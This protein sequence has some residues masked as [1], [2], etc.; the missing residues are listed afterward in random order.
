[1]CGGLGRGFQP[2]LRGRT[3]SEHVVF[4]SACVWDNILQQS[5]RRVTVMRALKGTRRMSVSTKGI[6]ELCL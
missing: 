5:L 3:V 4:G 2:F 1:M 6:A